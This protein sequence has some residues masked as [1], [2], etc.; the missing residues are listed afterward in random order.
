MIIS[1]MMAGVL[2]SSCECLTTRKYTRSSSSL[3]DR[4]PRLFRRKFR[5]RTPRRFNTRFRSIVPAYCL[6]LSARDL[7]RHTVV[8][9]FSRFR[10][11]T[12]SGSLREASLFWRR[13]M[14]CGM[15][16]HDVWRETSLHTLSRFLV[17]RLFSSFPRYYPIRQSTK[18][19]NSLP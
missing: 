4:R 16:V 14:I 2:R 13:D 11:T 15:R 1:C 18:G 12:L 6:R 17:G 5:T 10:D 19:F 8:R 7:V 9:R 3:G